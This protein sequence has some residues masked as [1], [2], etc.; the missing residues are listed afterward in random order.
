M[1]G[2]EY[3]FRHPLALLRVSAG[4]SQ[5]ELAS[6]VAEVHER[7]GFG[8]IGSYRKRVSR[9]ESWQVTPSIEAQYSLAAIFGVSR[10]QVLMLGWPRWLRLATSDAGSS[11]Y[12]WT[13][14]GTVESLCAVSQQT[15]EAPSVFLPISGPDIVSLADS[16]QKA[17]TGQS[18]VLSR[19]GKPSDP[20]VVDAIESR[21]QGLCEL[22]VSVEPATL[23]AAVRGELHL[24]TVLLRTTG[25]EHQTGVR[26]YVLAAR[27]ANAYAE[28]MESIGDDHRSQSYQLVAI[29]AAT[30]AGDV[31]LAAT[32]MSELV[33]L[34]L[35]SREPSDA[36]ALADRTQAVARGQS[37]RFTALLYA[38]RARAH[39]LLGD[40]R[41]GQQDLETAFGALPEGRGWRNADGEHLL[42]AVD[43]GRMSLTA[44]L[45]W[46]HLGR[47]RRALEYLAP[48]FSGSSN[49]AGLAYPQLRAPR[50]ALHALDAYL[51][52]AQLDMALNT[53]HW[54]LD[55]VG[56]LPPAVANQYRRRFVRHNT[57]PAA[58]E[59]LARL[60]EQTAP[61][62]SSD[63]PI[64]H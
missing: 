25:Y 1:P 53:A 26:L 6:L 35:A 50:W 34:H 16:W 57:A 28:L 30:T 39:A 41:G 32:L 40:T 43:P 33:G 54:V 9:W 38:R 52:V 31:Q 44:G 56:N 60:T 27:I 45:V 13:P 63:R 10:E 61:D 2:P 59:L 11:V 46:Y 64:D 24:V 22:V 23:V 18:P 62:T 19:S 3:V 58:R 49:P 8:V 17:V 29:R 36:L 21:V 14:E 55:L 51:A 15:H 48:L 12:P 7:L 4:Y 20:R 37:P 42:G 5:T 47:P